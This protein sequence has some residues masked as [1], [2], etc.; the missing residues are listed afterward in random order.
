MTAPALVFE[1]VSYAYQEAA[2]E[3]ISDL[4]LSIAEGEWVGVTGPT[5]FWDGVL[6]TRMRSRSRI[7]FGY[8]HFDT[9][10]HT[11]WEMTTKT[12]DRKE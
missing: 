11:R 3:S 2:R 8:L 4:D 5:Q 9:A 7:R 6:V 1:N 12:C 10:S